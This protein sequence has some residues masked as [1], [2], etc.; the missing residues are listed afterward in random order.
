MA[1]S[2]VIGMLLAVTVASAAADEAT[3]AR[4]DWGTIVEVPAGTGRHEARVDRWPA[5]GRLA[6]PQGFPQIVRAT[7]AEAD[8]PPRELAVELSA[9]ATQVAVL[10]PQPPASGSG[11]LHLHTAEDS[12]QFPDGRIVFTARDARVLG[13]KAKL[14]SHPGNHR[15]GFWSDAADAVQWQRGGTRWGR[16][17]AWLTYSTASPTGTEIEVEV[18]GTKLPA[19]L[20]STGSWYRYTTLPLGRVYLPEAGPQQVTVRCTKKVGGAVMNLKAVT[21]EP[22]CEGTPPEQADDGSITLHGRDAAVL[23]TTLRYEPA[24]KKQTLGFRSR[25]EYA[26]AI[27]RQGRRPRHPAGPA[28]ARRCPLER[29]AGS[30]TG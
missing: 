7:L 18:N 16:Y 8:A 14:E 12:R 26:A 25:V 1:T 20:G 19:T 9:D 30:R 15:I 11:V 3:D 24:E 10:V 13:S 17:D 28:R 23:G 27:D 22:A 2:L 21:L 6:M 4:P 29:A 5:D